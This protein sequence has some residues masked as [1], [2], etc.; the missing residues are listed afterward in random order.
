MAVAVDGREWGGGCRS[1]WAIIVVGVIVVSFNS[2]LCV[3]G[4][5]LVVV[6]GCWVLR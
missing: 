6:S 4:G 3:F 1:A 5:A 2:F